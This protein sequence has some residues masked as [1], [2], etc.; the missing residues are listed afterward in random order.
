V[1]FNLGVHSD[2]YTIISIDAPK[3]SLD[4]IEHPFMIKML[5]KL[6]TKEMYFNIINDSVTA[7][8]Y[9]KVKN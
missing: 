3:K 4:K 8:S 2:F 1:K 5:N 6:S 7:I 9:S